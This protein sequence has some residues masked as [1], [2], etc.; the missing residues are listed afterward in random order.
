[1]ILLQ[2]YYFSRIGLPSK[3]LFVQ[4]LRIINLL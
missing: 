3:A 2:K 4:Y 1:M